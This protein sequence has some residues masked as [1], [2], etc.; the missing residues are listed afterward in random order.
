MPETKNRQI[1]RLEIRRSDGF[2]ALVASSDTSS[3]KAMMYDLN[4]F[5]AC[6]SILKNDAFKKKL[7]EQIELDFKLPDQTRLGYFAKIRWIQADAT[8]TKYGV[9]FQE[10]IKPYASAMPLLQNECFFDLPDFFS[11]NAF[12]YK[13]YLFFERGT[14]RVTGISEK[15]W[16]ISILDSEVILFKSQKIDIWFLG[17]SSPVS[18]EV[19]QIKKGESDSCHIQCLVLHIPKEISQWI[20][21]QLIFVCDLTPVES[22][23]VGFDTSMVSNGFRF[24]FVKTQDEYESILKLRFKA[25]LEA[26]KIDA[27]KTFWDM[28]APLDHQS[29]ILIC[30]HGEKTVASVSISFPNHENEILDTERAFPNGYP[31]KIPP[32]KDI[33]EIARLCT[34]SDYRR[35][36]LLNRV[37]EYTYKVTVCGDRQYILTSS[38]NKLWP[39]Y[40]KLG[41]KKTGMSYPHPYLS[42]LE[43]HI[44]VGKREQPDY[45]KN[46]SPLAW[47]YL[48]RD[49]NF[50]MEERGFIKKTLLQKIRLK[51]YLLIGK[52]LK[53]QTERFY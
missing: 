33:V 45:G 3:I 35:T 15:V 50:H 51:I 31:V 10:Q 27:S 14:L 38:D 46:I 39:L 13:P 12:Y 28:A 36:D 48:W 5:G 22:R 18:L 23:R 2:E 17:H 25:Y 30:Y 7:N 11:L 52:I 42:G 24:R 21:H 16:K 49:M 47:N 19:I 26:G 1:S 43:H 44:I 37:F 34:D 6:I 32:K 53:I 40:K 8:T 4:P 9:E 29:R 20:A 41:F